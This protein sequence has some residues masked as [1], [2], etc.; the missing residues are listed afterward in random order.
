MPQ[1]TFVASFLLGIILVAALI[2]LL[3]RGRFRYTP[4]FGNG[5]GDLAT[6]ILTLARRPVTWTVSFLAVAMFAGIAT[7]LAVGG[8][9]VSPSVAGGATALLAAVG[10]IVLVGYV[11]YGTFVAARSRGL[12]AAQAAAFGSWAVGL[13][14]L[15]AVAASLVGLF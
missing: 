14:V 9:D 8:F 12:H 2:G 15:V 4:S 6:G 10:T 13:L 5:D 1:S 7:V 3:S 11:F